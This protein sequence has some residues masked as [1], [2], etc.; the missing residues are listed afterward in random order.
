MELLR[1][2]KIF[3]ARKRIFY[4][5][6]AATVILSLIALLLIKPTYRASAKVLAKTTVAN[7]L[8]AGWG[9][10]S[11]MTSASEDVKTDI[12]LARITPLARE[13]INE[14]KLTGLFGK[15]LQAEYFFEP[16]LA[17]NLFSLPYAIVKQYKEASIIEIS[18]VSRDPELSASIANALSSH[19]IEGSIQRIKVDFKSVRE[20]IEYRLESIRDDYYKS[21]ALSRDIKLRDMTVDLSSETNNLIETVSTLKTDLETIDKEIAQY[22]AEIVKGTK[23]LKELA[24]YRKETFEVSKNQRL[25]TL[26]SSLDDKILERASQKLDL[27]KEHPKYKVLTE[28][29]ETIKKQM[30]AEADLVLSREVK[31]LN[32]THTELSRKILTSYINKEAALAKKA[33]M[34]KFMKFYQ[35]KLIKIPHKYEEFARIDP[36]LAAQK[37]MYVKISQYA[38]QAGLAESISLSKLKVV[39]P[40]STPKKRFYP[41]RGRSLL[42]ALFLG[43][44]LGLASVFFAEYIDKA[45]NLRADIPQQSLF[46]GAIPYCESLRNYNA[47]KSLAADSKEIKAIDEIKDNIFYESRTTLPVVV[48]SPKKGDGKTITASVLAIAYA[49]DGHRVLLVGRRGSGSSQAAEFFGM[50]DDDSGVARPTGVSGLDM[51]YVPNITRANE[52]IGSLGAS[53]DQVVIDTCSARDC[54]VLHGNVICVIEPYK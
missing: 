12:E 52:I 2:L 21:L 8:L 36:L 31:S 33:V 7:G 40:A 20:S 24:L 29:I 15:P 16:S 6:L 23:Q 37:D 41:R 46:L 49:T 5:V 1:Y 22:E 9:L 38:I 44:F 3:S 43:V 19:Y 48:I 47:M 30:S 18:V 32:P 34:I 39:E 51:L 11:Q 50:A 10:S 26:K 54:S 13:I 35:E 25:E 42:S 17:E 28:E 53:Y 4:Y 27:T 45:V 14:Y